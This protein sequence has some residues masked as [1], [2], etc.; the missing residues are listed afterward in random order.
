MVTLNFD[1]TIFDRSP[2]AKSGLQLGSKF[3]QTIFVQLQV[4]NYR[5]ALASPP[6][7]FS[8]YPS[9]AGFTG[10]GRLVRAGASFLEL[11]ALGAKQFSPIVISHRRITFSF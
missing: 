5:D 6:L 2:G 9:H 8:T 11:V 4:G 7:C 1:P 3:Q 10:N